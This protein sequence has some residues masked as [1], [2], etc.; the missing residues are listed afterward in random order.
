M[1]NRHMKITLHKTTLPMQAVIRSSVPYFL[2]IASRRIIASEQCMFP[3][4]LQMYDIWKIWKKKIVTVFV[5]DCNKKSAWI[6]NLF[7]FSKER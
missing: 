1:H 6:S 7:F 5:K 4:I 3:Q 2:H